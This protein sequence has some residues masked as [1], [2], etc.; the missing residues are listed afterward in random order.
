MDH[1]KLDVLVVSV[2]EVRR[3]THGCIGNIREASKTLDVMS[4]LA[5][6]SVTCL[7]KP[8]FWFIHCH[9]S[10]NRI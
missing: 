6:I 1:V 10:V 3:H 5:R 2:K 9:D 8:A 7:L 4:R